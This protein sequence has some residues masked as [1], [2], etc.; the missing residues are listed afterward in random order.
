MAVA[1]G[2]GV[3]TAMLALIL[4]G[5]EQERSVRESLY[6]RELILVARDR[7]YRGFFEA[8]KT[9]PVLSIGNAT[10]KPFKFYQENLE[11]VRKACPAVQYGYITQYVGVAESGES[12]DS[13]RRREV[14]L[15]GVSKEYIDAASLKLLAGSWPTNED[16]RSHNRL[17]L[18]SEWYARQRFEKKIVDTNA[19]PNPAAKSAQ[20][21]TLTS[22]D[23]K[24]L[25]NQQVAPKP[26]DLKNVVGKDIYS[27]KIIG[28]FS[29]P[30]QTPEFAS[31]QQPF[32]AKGITVFGEYRDLT[33][34]S[35]SLEDLKFLARP[36]QF[37]AA[38][39]QLRTYATRRWG[40][41]TDVRSNVAE[42]TANLSTARNAALV[43]V[44]F[45]SGGLVIAAL[46]ITNLM[47]ARVLGRTRSIGISSALGAS[48][49]TIFAL[50][51]TESLVLGLIG[52]LLG[53]LLARGITYGLEMSL[54]SAS[55]FSS[56]MDLTLQPLHFAI[57]L[58]TAL[59]V[60]LLFGVYPAWMAARI[61]PSEA[62]RG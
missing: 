10:E 16:F 30:G 55:Q 44:L 20:T 22:Q 25:Q 46:N 47:L 21:K 4:N 54:Q 39:D 1:L 50:F 17:I 42:L 7:D 48:S 52:G 38:R 2:V 6:A 60:S 36:D 34:S 62:L 56:G 49:R 57:G 3:V 31:N 19:K 26:F 24:P 40:E 32:G 58:L 35:S 15:M 59:L 53:I 28:V 33:F 11:T 9:N 41:G 12:D 61:R 5:L 23:K 29:I 13:S 51:L 8:G 45:A 27:Y 43:T 37:D 14:D 18:L